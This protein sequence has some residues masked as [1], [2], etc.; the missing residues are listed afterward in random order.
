[1][2][3]PGLIFSSLLV[4]IFSIA[5]TPY[6]DLKNHQLGYK[7]VQ[8]AYKEK[9][10]TIKAQ[11]LGKGI[12]AEGYDL[13]L[14]AFKHEGVLE[15]WIKPQGANAYQLFKSY[16]ICEVSGTLGPKTQQGDFQTPEGFYY[17]DR[18]NPQSNFYLSLGINYPNRADRIRSNASNLGGDIFIHGSC[19]TVGCLPMND[20]QIKEIYVLSVEAKNNGQ[21]QIPVH[22]F[23]YKINEKIYSDEIFESPKKLN[24]EERDLIYFWRNLGKGMMAFDDTHTLPSVSIDNEGNYQ[25]N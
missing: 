8:E 22:I 4:F 15:A 7:R 11:L 6:I 14:R 18:F 9:E 13:Y 16:D 25:F 1:M 21:H 23:P 19:E 5:A 24:Q 2:K 10:A 3:K 17:I 12:T 20:D